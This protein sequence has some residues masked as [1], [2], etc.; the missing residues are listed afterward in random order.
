[1]KIVIDGTDKEIADLVLAIQGQQVQKLGFED[2]K[3]FHD[4][5]KKKSNRDKL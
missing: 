1:M 4:E 5:I 3:K 2:F